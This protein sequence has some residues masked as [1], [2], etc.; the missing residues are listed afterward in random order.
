LSLDEFS[1][2]SS[3]DELKSCRRDEEINFFLMVDVFFVVV[4]AGSCSGVVEITFT[5]D[6]EDD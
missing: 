6:L 2:S 5:F 3:V 1:S 4:A